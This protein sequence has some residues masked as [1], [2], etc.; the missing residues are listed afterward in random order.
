MCAHNSDQS[1]QCCFSSPAGQRLS[2]RSAGGGVLRR[3]SQ[4]ADRPAEEKHPQL[5][6]LYAALQEMALEGENGSAVLQ[7]DH[8]HLSVIQVRLT[9]MTPNR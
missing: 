1:D 2:Q 7:S 5:F 9:L 3:L 8:S 6:R 4:A